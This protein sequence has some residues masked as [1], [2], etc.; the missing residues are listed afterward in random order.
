MHYIANSELPQDLRK[1]L[2]P[3]AQDLYR[4]VFNR[5]FPSSR[6]AIRVNSEALAH[7]AAWRAVKQSC[8]LRA[9]VWVKK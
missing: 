1:D 2:S 5:N 8:E 4:E 6:N 9:G 3:D 7:E